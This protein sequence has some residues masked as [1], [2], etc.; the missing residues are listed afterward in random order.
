MGAYG[1]P[2]LHPKLKESTPPPKRKI[3]A[4]LKRVSFW[5]CALCVLLEIAFDDTHNITGM[6]L[7]CCVSVFACEGAALFV[8]AIRER[9]TKTN[10][11][12]VVVSI[13]LYLATAFYLGAKMICFHCPSEGQIEEV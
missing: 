2:E 4:T 5:L 1:S 11:I 9:K 6:F 8:N 12:A 7:A 10:A 3:P 13:V